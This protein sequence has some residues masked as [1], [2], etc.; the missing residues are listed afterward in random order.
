MNYLAIQSIVRIKRQK[1]DLFIQ[2]FQQLFHARALLI[3]E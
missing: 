3:P 1:N 2:F